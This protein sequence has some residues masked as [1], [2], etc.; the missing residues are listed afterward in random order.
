MRVLVTGGAGF[1][2]SNFIRY[3]FS[4][5]GGCSIT[6]LDKLTYCGNRNN[7]ADI[8]SRKGYRFIKADICDMDA[9]FPA[10]K[11]C[12]VIVNFAAESHVDRSIKDPE[13]FIKT[14]VN[15]VRVLLEA[16]VKCKVSRF[17]QI[18]TDEVYGDVKKGFSKEEDALMPNSPYAASKAAADLL[19]RSYHKTYGLPVIITRSSNNFGPYQ[20]PEKMIPLFLTNAIEGKPLPVYGRGKNVRDWLYVIDNCSGI[21][22]VMRKARP[23]NIY[24]ISGDRRIKNIN[25]AKEILRIIG[26]GE[27]LISFVN[28]RPC[29]DTRYAMDSKKIKALGWR[30]LFDFDKA[31]MLTAQW[32]MKNTN[33][34][35]DLKRRANIIRW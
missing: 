13:G 9:V 26:R 7:L 2:G 19:C 28:D 1:I 16:A 4:R 33:W 12:D 17:I 22:Y 3:M 25:I 6:N 18:S 30:P 29:H 32:Y 24:N 20:Y 27:R 8:G 34:W 35:Q 14:N 23:G 11:G 21:D 10:A 15:G 31:L 5:Y